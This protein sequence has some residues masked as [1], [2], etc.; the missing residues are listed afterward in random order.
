MWN[1]SL[2]EEEIREKKLYSH[3]LQIAVQPGELIFND[4]NEDPN[5]DA[6]SLSAVQICRNCAN[7]FS[8]YVNVRNSLVQKIKNAVKVIVLNKLC[9]APLNPL[10]SRKRKGLG[11][12]GP[13]SVPPVLCFM[14]C[15]SMFG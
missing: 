4:F 8:T 7:S 6:T 13:T 3:S 11:D 9:N 12:N 15:F 10:E 1:R 14:K 2:C 5:T